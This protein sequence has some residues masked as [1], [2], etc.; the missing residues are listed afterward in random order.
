[1]TQQNLLELARQGNVKAIATLLQRGLQSQ[2]ITV[3]VGTKKDCLMVFLESDAVHEEETLVEFIK[4]ELEKLKV[5]FFHFVKIYTRWKGE[6]HSVLIEEFEI[7]VNTEPSLPTG[8]ILRK[9][10]PQDYFK[11]T[12]QNYGT[13]IGGFLLHSLIF[14]ALSLALFLYFLLG[15]LIVFI[16]FNHSEILI[17]I[18]AITIFIIITILFVIS[19]KKAFIDYLLPFFKPDCYTSNLWVIEMESTG[20]LV[21]FGKLNRS[22]GKLYIQRLFVASALQ[23]RGLGSALVKRLIQEATLPLYVNSVPESVSFYTRLGFV[24]LPK[25][26]SLDPLI[27]LVYNDDSGV[28]SE[29]R[30]IN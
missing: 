29:N 30:R 28:S 19:T 20:Y 12:K 10:I 21:A 14:L 4:K 6:T 2:A 7:A 23:R 13:L 15:V 1:M 8:Y 17:T 11:I 27:P 25:K 16:T 22:G 24:S 26:D 9:A 5:N 18:L 3:K